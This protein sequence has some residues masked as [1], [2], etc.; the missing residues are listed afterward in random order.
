MRLLP[1]KRKRSGS[2]A[3]VCSG[4]PV[5]VLSGVPEDISPGVSADVSAG[6]SDAGVSVFP[7]PP[8]PP[9]DAVPISI[10]AARANSRMF[11]ILF[12]ILTGSGLSR[13]P[14]PF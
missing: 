14:S 12:M 2:P 1:R 9:Q 4:L 10:D 3:E 6:E 5:S 11:F 13:F 8:A 7:A